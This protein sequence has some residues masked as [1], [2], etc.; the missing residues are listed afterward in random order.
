MA[1]RAER[2]LPV[3]PPREVEPR[4]RGRKR[5]A[6]AYRRILVPLIDTSDSE[7][8]V[9]VA[10]QLGVDRGASVSAVTVIEVPVELPL[11]AHM[12]DEEAHAKHVLRDAAAIGDRYGVT[13]APRILRGRSAGEAIVH[14]AKRARSEIVVLWAPRRKR[15]GSKAAIF[16]RTVDYVMKHAPCRVMVTAAPATN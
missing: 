7:R 3:P 9:A 4:P 15:L 11:D 2:R 12:T 5:A 1:V 13:V 8:A 14:E 10:C 16:G 6:V